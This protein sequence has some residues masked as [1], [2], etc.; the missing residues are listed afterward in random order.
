MYILNVSM[1]KVYLRKKV[2]KQNIK[3]IKTN[4]C[5]MSIRTIGHKIPCFGQKKLSNFVEGRVLRTK[6]IEN[7]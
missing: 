4:T 7:L 6:T 5:A 2:K 3:N 1:L